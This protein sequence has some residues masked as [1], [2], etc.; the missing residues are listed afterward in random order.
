MVS[1][2]FPR[3]AVSQFQ[4]GIIK[5][6]FPNHVLVIIQIQIIH[7]PNHSLSELALSYHHYPHHQCSSVQLL[8]MT[9][10]NK[11]LHLKGLKRES[12]KTQIRANGL[13]ASPKLSIKGCWY[14]YQ[15]LTVQKLPDFA[16]IPP[17]RIVFDVISRGGRASPDGADNTGTWWASFA[18]MERLLYH[19]FY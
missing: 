12:T 14:I 7:Y 16:V 17:E 8:R 9:K 4:N 13:W 15:H 2:R 19:H 6:E 10:L 1:S 3:I 5:N 11:H 18:N